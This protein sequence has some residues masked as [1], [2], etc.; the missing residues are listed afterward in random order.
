MSETAKADQQI[1]ADEINISKQSEHVPLVNGMAVNP[2]QQIIEEKQ[3]ENQVE[4]EIRYPY[5]KEHL[6]GNEE[7][8]NNSG[9]DFVDKLAET[10]PDDQLK[11]FPIHKE[12]GSSEYA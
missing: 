11:K 3:A 2:S 9:H 7:D 5:N 4:S 1:K 8:L 6:E 10:F 12:A